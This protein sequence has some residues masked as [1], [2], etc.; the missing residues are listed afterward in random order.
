MIQVEEVLRYNLI[1]AISMKKDE[2]IQLGM[3]YGL[4][5]YKTIKCSQQLD[6]L[7]NIHRNG[8]QYFLN[9]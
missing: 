4:A 7:L 3:K 8:T 1:E 6:K 9:H 2:M 5:H